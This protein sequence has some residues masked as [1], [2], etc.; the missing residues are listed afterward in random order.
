MNHGKVVA[1]WIS[2]Y[3]DKY[4]FV[5]TSIALSSSLEKKTYKRESLKTKPLYRY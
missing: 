5:K 2:S 1:F 3:I 4:L